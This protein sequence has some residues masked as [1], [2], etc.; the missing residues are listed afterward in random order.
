[1]LQIWC[2]VTLETLLAIASKAVARKIVN[3]VGFKVIPKR[4]GS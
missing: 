3:Q 2:F 4:L 1:M